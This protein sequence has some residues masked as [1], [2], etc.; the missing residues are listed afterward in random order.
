M[1]LIT[2]LLIL[3][4]VRFPRGNARYVIE[5]T[6][7]SLTNL[8]LQHGQSVGVLNVASRS[9]NAISICSGYG[10]I[11]LGLRE[12]IPIRTIC[13]V[14][15]ELPAATILAKRMEE[16][17]LDK[18]P[19]W[20]NLKSFDT[21][22][23]RGKVD[24]LTGGFPCQ[25][26]SVAGNQL[27]EDDPRNLWPDTARLIRGLG[28]PIVFLENVPGILRYY[29]DTIRP[30]LREMGYTVTEGLFSAAETGASHKRQR[31]FILAYRT[32]QGLQ[33]GESSCLGSSTTAQS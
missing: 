17:H 9:L 31:I 32:A 10:G 26:F 6:I 27:G 18:A 14:E 29:Y 19:V 11:E 5:H 24:I 22:P 25:P 4:T 33:K 23:W 16:G 21:E 12:V 2:G 28:V 7:I 13:Y 20:S 8:S 15:I 30:E 1:D 3:P